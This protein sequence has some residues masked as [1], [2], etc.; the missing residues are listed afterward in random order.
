MSSSQ[1]AVCEPDDGVDEA[2]APPSI[3]DDTIFEG[4]F[5]VLFPT[6]P[7]QSPDQQSSFVDYCGQRLGVASQDRT[8]LL[9]RLLRNHSIDLVVVATPMHG[10]PSIKAVYT[11]TPTTSPIWGSAEPLLLSSPP[12]SPV[13]VNAP[14]GT[15]TE[16]LPQRGAATP[17]AAR[18]EEPENGLRGSLGRMNRL[19]RRETQKRVRKARLRE[20]LR[21]GIRADI[22]AKD[23]STE[24]HMG[25]Q[26]VRSLRS[27]VCATQW[28]KMSAWH[29]LGA[30]RRYCDAPSEDAAADHGGD[31]GG[32]GG[33][34]GGGDRDP[35]VAPEECDDDPQY[36]ARVRAILGMS[37][38]TEQIHAIR[39]LPP[40]A[41]NA[42]TGTIVR[43]APAKKRN[44]KNA[45][46]RTNKKKKTAAPRK[47]QRDTALMQC[48]EQRRRIEAKINRTVKFTGEYVRTNL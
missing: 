23:G 41:F 30:F 22:E 12:P 44:P 42:R 32:G 7:M 5:A 4:V 48:R 47:K 20:F 34:G 35:E 43:L 8:A 11:T 38:A 16:R 13:A 19:F 2:K 36:A 6:Y 21:T 25:I 46:R 39:A 27:D 29:R 9:R 15:A 31:G 40:P 10:R 17:L 24:R 26:W 18:E 28:G 37:D 45:T 1:A 14:A 33:G 3:S